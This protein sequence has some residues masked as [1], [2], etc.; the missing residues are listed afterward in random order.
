MSDQQ[1]ALGDSG[2]LSLEVTARTETGTLQKGLGS[3][4]QL[5]NVEA[6]RRAHIPPPGALHRG[7]YSAGQERARWEE[8]EGLCEQEP[9]C[10]VVQ[11]QEAQEIQGPP[12][13]TFRRPVL[14]S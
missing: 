3:A 9:V 6:Q 2:P 11:E 10:P 13:E 12:L 1:R 8:A 5:W 14:L 4:A 7:A